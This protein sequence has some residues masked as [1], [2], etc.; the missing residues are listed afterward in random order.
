MEKRLNH[1]FSS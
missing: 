1:R